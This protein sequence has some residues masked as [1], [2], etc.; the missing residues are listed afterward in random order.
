MLLIAEYRLYELC[1]CK[2]FRFQ[3]FYPVWRS[4]GAAVLIG[5]K[6]KEEKSITT[7][8][9]SMNNLNKQFVP[10]PDTPHRY[11]TA[12]K[13]AKEFLMSQTEIYKEEYEENCLLAYVDH[14]SCL[15]GS[16]GADR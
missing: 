11:S 2:L 7:D 3:K 5:K 8:E 4:C 16:G 14:R 9:K 1:S 13:C 10:D 6:V 12:C 15:F